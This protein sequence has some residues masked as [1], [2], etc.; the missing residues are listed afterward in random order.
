MKK[1]ILKGKTTLKGDLIDVI[2]Q[3]M[4]ISKELIEEI[5]LNK[6]MVTTNVRKKI[7]AEKLNELA[8]SIKKDTLL[9][10]VI[11]LKAEND[12]YELLFGQRRYYAMVKLSKENPGEYVKI[13]CIVKDKDNYDELEV[14]KLQLSEN[15]HREDLNFSELKESLVKLREMNMS[16]QEIADCLKKSV[17][18]V[19]N[20]FS[21][22]N[23]I[24]KNPD[25]KELVELN[26]VVKK[27][28][29]QVVQG[30]PVKHQAELIKKRISGEIK[31]IKELREKTAEIKDELNL[32]KTNR[33]PKPKHNYLSQEITFKNTKHKARFFKQ[34]FDLHELSNY[35]RDD[36]IHYAKCLI[37]F[38]QGKRKL[39]EEIL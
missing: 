17:G 33:T 16:N 25:L 7:N 23:T 18:W 31:S 6:I 24:D 14:I 10:P 21:V 26:D 4:D 19:N 1:Q 38:L 39:D 36:I 12:K 37:K 8:E 35:E 15:L 2:S 11:V 9:Q 34:T 32:N 22:V 27:D 30:L 5:E 20:A 3:K 28:D 13:K 29:V